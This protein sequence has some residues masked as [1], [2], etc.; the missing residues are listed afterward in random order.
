MKKTIATLAA[1]ASA[2][3]FAGALTLITPENANAGGYSSCSTIGTSTFC[4]G[5]DSNGNYYSGSS[6]TIGGTT[7]YN[8]YGSGGNSFGGSC[9]TIGST[10]FCNSY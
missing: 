6:N 5:T 2:A 3:L 10:T 1:A 7:F 8:G 4:S 9:S